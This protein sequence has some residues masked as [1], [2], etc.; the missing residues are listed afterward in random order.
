MDTPHFECDFRNGT[1]QVVTLISPFCGNAKICKIVG[2]REAFQ[3]AKRNIE[4]SY[5]VIGVLEHFK[6]SLRLYELA[7]PQFFS[8]VTAVIILDG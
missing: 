7:L 1:N 3:R 6:A 2:N 4:K 8:G 5:P